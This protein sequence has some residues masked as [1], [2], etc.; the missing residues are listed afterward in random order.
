MEVGSS[1]APK[2][3]IAVG[4]RVRLPRGAEPPIV[5][6]MNG[7]K[8]T[9][10]ADYELRRGEIVFSRPI[11]KEQV[12]GIRWL[13]MLLGLFGTYRK[14]ETVDVEYRLRGQ[15]KLASDVEILG[16]CISR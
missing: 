10:G 2:G 9:E 1:E 7:V 15:V 4:R 12:G 16:D 14:H 11:V 6:Y 3:S 5:V 8:Q 13:A